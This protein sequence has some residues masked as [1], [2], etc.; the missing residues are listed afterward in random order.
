MQMMEAIRS[1][2]WGL[3]LL[4]EVHVVPAQMFRKVIGIVKSHCKLGLTATLVREDERIGDL[5]FLIGPKMYEANW[6]DLTKAG[7]IANVQC[8]EVWCPMTKEFFAEYLKTDHAPLRYCM[9]DTL[10]SVRTYDNSGKLQGM[11]SL[12]AVS[13]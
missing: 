7:H 3:L 6:L 9:S 2:E 13:E 12:P 11:L 8:A 4:D 1:R 10:S 5:N